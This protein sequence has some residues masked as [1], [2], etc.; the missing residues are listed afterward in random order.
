MKLKAE[1]VGTVCA[2]IY[3]GTAEN[4]TSSEIIDTTGAGD[5][6]IGAVLYGNLPPE[7]VVIS[8]TLDINLSGIIKVFSFILDIDKFGC[9]MWI[10]LLIDPRVSQ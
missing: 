9:C 3:R 4:I 5:A 1:G 8:L 6:F 10:F 2:K 7:L